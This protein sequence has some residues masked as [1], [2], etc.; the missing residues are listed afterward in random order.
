MKRLE[1]EIINLRIDKRA[2]EQVITMLH[3][4]RREMHAQLQDISYRLDA[5]ETRVEQLDAP[6]HDDDTARQSRLRKLYRSRSV[7]GGGHG[8]YTASRRAGA[9]G[10][11]AAIIFWPASRVGE[12]SYY[13]HTV[14]GS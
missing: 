5:S 9:E 11:A 8:R 1:S 4:E 14:A 10:G 3:E 13:P 6:K 7:A 12:G 2:K